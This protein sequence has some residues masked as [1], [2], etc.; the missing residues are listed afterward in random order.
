MFETNSVYEL[1]HFDCLVHEC[2]EEGA[3]DQAWICVDN[4]ANMY[5]FF[6]L[7]RTFIQNKLTTDTVSLGLKALP[8]DY[9]NNISCQN[10]STQQFPQIYGFL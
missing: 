7:C 6:Y 9:E 5:L 1:F 10:M 3:N 4:T 2:T 8:K